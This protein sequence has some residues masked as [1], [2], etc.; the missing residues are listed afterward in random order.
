MKT[1]ADNPEMIKANAILS[2]AKHAPYLGLDGELLGKTFLIE[3]EEWK[4]VGLNQRVRKNPIVAENAKGELATFSFAD[5]GV[6][7]SLVKL[8]GT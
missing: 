6:V 8:N 2:F 4:I 3:R 7:V 5:A 1:D